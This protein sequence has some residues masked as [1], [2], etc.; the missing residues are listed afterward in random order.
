[1]HSAAVKLNR[2]TEGNNFNVLTR[3]P[4]EDK[5]KIEVKFYESE[6]DLVMT[7]SAEEKHEINRLI[8]DGK[9]YNEAY[10]LIKTKND[11]KI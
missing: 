10:K 2:S 1:M 9:G 8:A 5:I 7:L 3:L 6:P 4:M 11:A